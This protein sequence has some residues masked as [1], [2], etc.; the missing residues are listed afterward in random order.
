MSKNSFK[1]IIFN[2]VFKYLFFLHNTECHVRGI[3]HTFEKWKIEIKISQNRL[4]AN[5]NKS[6][7]VFIPNKNVIIISLHF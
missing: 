4:L 5:K 3:L 2:S 1:Y 7:S 6:K